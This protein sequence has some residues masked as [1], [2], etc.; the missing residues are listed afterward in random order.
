[1]TLMALVGPDGAVVRLDRNIDPKA[2]TKYGYSWRPV[3]KDKPDFDP[4]TQEQ[5]GP[6][7][8]VEENRVVRRWT[9]TDKSAEQLAQEADDAKE[10]ETNALGRLALRV[11]LSHENRMRKLEGRGEVTPAQ[12]RKTIKKMLDAGS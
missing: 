12:F 10:R 3:E 4:L 7:L 1:M 11:L 6:D 5:S 2:G 8:I 9:V